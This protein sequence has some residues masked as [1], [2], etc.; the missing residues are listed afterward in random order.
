MGYYNKRF[1]SRKY[2]LAPEENYK[3]DRIREPSKDDGR[4]RKMFNIWTVI[5]ACV[6]LL[7]ISFVIPKTAVFIRDRRRNDAFKW[8]KDSVQLIR[9]ATMDS[10]A[11]ISEYT[12]FVVER[13]D[14]YYLFWYTEYAP[15]AQ[16]HLVEM[17]ESS[18]YT[19]PLNVKEGESVTYPFKEAPIAEVDG[20]I[21][22]SDKL[23]VLKGYRIVSLS[24]NEEI[25]RERRSSVYMYTLEPE[26]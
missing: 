24:D 14:R 11:M 2:R 12:M 23:E 5:A 19:L 3:L 13:G 17:G 4:Q 6:L 26:K 9:K 15:D 22:L 18:K 7:I 8:A 1:K 21:K 20:N 16:S 10:G 25:E